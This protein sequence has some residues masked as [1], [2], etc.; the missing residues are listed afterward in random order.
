ML[1]STGCPIASLCRD[2]NSEMA[3]FRQNRKFSV[4]I[5]ELVAAGRLEDA[6]TLC[7]QQ[8]GSRNLG[9]RVQDFVSPRCM[10]SAAA[11]V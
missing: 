11:A 9:F 3:D 7:D 6:K 2:G 1:T 5:R 4:H 8:V 10:Y